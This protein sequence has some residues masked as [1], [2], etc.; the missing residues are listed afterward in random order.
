MPSTRNSTAL[1]KVDGRQRLLD[2]AVR[3]LESN[4]EV[5]LRMATIAAEAGV[6]IALITH[7]FGS[8]DGL[9]EAAQRARVQGAVATDIDFI[10]DV[11]ANPV[12][13][14][15]FRGQLETMM[16]TILD[17]ARSRMRL[18]RL[19]ALASAHGREALKAE[20]GQEITSV[21]TA[22]QD[23]VERAQWRGVFR[24]DIDPRSTAVFIQ[25]V[26]M[27]MVLADLDENA[28]DW[29]RI[30]HTVMLAF[31]SFLLPSTPGSVTPS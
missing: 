18:A 24:G 3:W 15:E 14:E 17:D 1:E 8:R 6:T 7:H 16:R 10:Q 19:A 31:D 4:S 21:V 11:L 25:A 30:L 12:S 20:L 5:D 29:D 22:I 26:L 2:A 28:P 9:I 27:G 13:V 23:C